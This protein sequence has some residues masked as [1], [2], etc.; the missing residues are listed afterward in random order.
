[1]KQKMEI[2]ERITIDLNRP[3]NLGDTMK[4]FLIVIVMTIGVIVGSWIQKCT[5]GN[6][7]TSASSSTQS[8]SHNTR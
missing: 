3:A 1:V 4:R 6:T 2:L 5:N 8:P 7:A